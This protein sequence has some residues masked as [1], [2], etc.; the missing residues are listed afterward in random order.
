MSLQKNKEV[1]DIFLKV[2]AERYFQEESSLNQSILYSLLAPG[3]RIRPLLCMGFSHGFMGDSNMAL[4]CAVAVEMIHTYSLIH[5]DLPAMDDDDFRR[6]RASNHKV[7]GEALAILAGDSLLNFAPQFLL[8]ELKS[9]KV[10]PAL[11][12]ELTAKLMES[13]GH[14]GMVKGQALDIQY[15]AVDLTNDKKNL[16]GI[17]RLIHQLKTGALINWC[18]V[19]GL[20]SSANQAMIQRNLAKVEVVGKKL[21]LLFQM[22][23][24]VLDVT[25]SLENL[26]KTPGKDERTGKLTYVS[27]YGL[28]EASFMAKELAQE[29]H[30]GL[31]DLNE[32]Q[33]DWTM[34]SE[35]VNSLTESLN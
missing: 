5:D 29:I 11:M 33:G 20:Y 21:G 28:K 30:R 14:L 18:C 13:S 24:D 34:I 23:D 3:K 31:E 17:L 2:Q 16:E 35:I 32:S 4:R 25:T 1:F 19:A 26:G 7:H 6:G 12:V 8:Q 10:D 9:L 22:V 15:E 27:L